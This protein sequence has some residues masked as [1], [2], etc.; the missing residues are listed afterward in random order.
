MQNIENLKTIAIGAIG[1]GT[2]AGVENLTALPQI[3]VS[4]TMSIVTQIVI[5]L[6]TLVGLFKK[7]DKVT[8]PKL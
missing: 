8:T 2:S 5:L 4:Q 7:K 3:D 1:A 6:A